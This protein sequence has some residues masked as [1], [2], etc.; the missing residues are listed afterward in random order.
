MPKRPLGL[1]LGPFLFEEWRQNATC[2]LQIEIIILW[3]HGMPCDLHTELHLNQRS[4][5]ERGHVKTPFKGQLV[6]HNFRQGPAAPPL[7]LAHQ[8]GHME[9]KI[10]PPE[11]PNQ[12]PHPGPTPP[13]G[14]ACVEN[15]LSSK[16]CF[17]TAPKTH[18][19]CKAHAEF[20]R[21]FWVSSLWVSH[22]PWSKTLNFAV[23]RPTSL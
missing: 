19:S 2:A 15:R 22:V 7:S 21:I 17:D 5:S 23:H 13:G 16:L 11:W 9:C 14:S 12:L 4:S 20:L 1:G 10:A 6:L 3:R 8:G 18:S